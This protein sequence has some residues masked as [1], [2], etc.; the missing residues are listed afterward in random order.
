MDVPLRSTRAARQGQCMLKRRPTRR[1][2]TPAPVKT[3]KSQRG[4]HMPSPP[5]T[6]LDAPPPRPHAHFFIFDKK[7][8]RR[9][10]GR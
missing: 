2:L 3:P 10:H 6:M 8:A 9:A 5:F 4:A 1:P 7:A